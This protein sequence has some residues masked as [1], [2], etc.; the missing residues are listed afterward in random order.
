MKSN[1]H[2]ASGK[3]NKLLD[4][5]STK[6]MSRNNK[7]SFLSKQPSPTIFN[8]IEIQPSQSEFGYIE[9]P[10]FHDNFGFR[11]N[12]AESPLSHLKPSGFRNQFSS[13]K[14]F[15]KVFKE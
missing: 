4:L 11:K 10:F 9:K 12:V 5:K 13:L 14:S 6:V 1:S 15:E 3:L 2:Q 8:N 7:S